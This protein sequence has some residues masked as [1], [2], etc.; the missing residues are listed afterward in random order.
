MIW[1]ELSQNLEPEEWGRCHSQ[2]A[3]VQKK[4]KQRSPFPETYQGDFRLG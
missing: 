2:L 3:S 4:S 1:S